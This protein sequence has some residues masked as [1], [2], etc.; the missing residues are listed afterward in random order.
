MF[1]F[2]G[3]ITFK[4]DTDIPD[5]SSKV[6]LVTG[7]NNGLGKESVRQFAKHGAKVYMGARSEKKATDA[8]AEIK[9]SLPNANIAF[10]EFDLT[11]FDSLKSASQN[12]LAENDRLDI[13]MNNGGIMAG[14]RGV[15]KEGYEMQFGTN[16]VGH[17]LLTRL[18]MPVLEKTAAE[19]DS[20][21]RIINLTSNSQELF[22]PKA[23]LLLDKVKT[24]MESTGPLTCYGHSK[25][26][27]VYFTK[28]LAKHYPQIKSVAVH[29]G[30]VQT[31]LSARLYAT[32]PRFKPILLLMRLAFADV[33]VGAH[34]QLWASTATSADVQNGALYYPVAKEHEGRPL[35]NDPEMVD[36]LWD[37]TETELKT[38]GF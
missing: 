24:D 18:L 9:Q 15:T 27:N 28:G 13:L 16:H 12:F 34:G 32:Y 6:I 26:A 36:S 10:L 17:A 19:Q 20:D 37:W 1:G 8:I 11:S 14:P 21:V 25:L 35:M 7:G 4:P 30:G 29:P 3:G 2:G 33:S 38:H 22:A 5:L 23:G 31:G